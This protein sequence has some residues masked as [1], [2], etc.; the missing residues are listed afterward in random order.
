M[1]TAA[2]EL[3]QL[4]FELCIAFMTEEFKDR[5]PSTSM[6]VYYSGIL[7]LQGDRESF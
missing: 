7:A 5:Q 3:L 6:L 2:A 1:Y 4:M